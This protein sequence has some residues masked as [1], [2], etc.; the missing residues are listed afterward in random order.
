MDG[1]YNRVVYFCG[2][3]WI[4]LRRWMGYDLKDLESTGQAKGSIYIGLL[5]DASTSD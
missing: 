3:N 4:W 1:P 2:V 5:D